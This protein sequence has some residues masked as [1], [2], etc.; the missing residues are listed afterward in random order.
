LSTAQSV[1]LLCN[2]TCEVT[3][4]A[5]AHNMK[6]YAKLNLTVSRN[7]TLRILVHTNVAGKVSAPI[8]NAEDYSSYVPNK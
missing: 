6:E 4:C 2:L 7:V 3:L 1:Y 8:L 5:W